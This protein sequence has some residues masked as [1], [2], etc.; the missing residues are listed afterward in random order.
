VNETISGSRASEPEE[1][2]KDYSI[3][4]SHRVNQ[5]PVTDP[6][7]D[8]HAQEAVLI[9]ACMSSD[10]SDCS[11]YTVRLVSSKPKHPKPTSLIIH[12]GKHKTRKTKMASMRLSVI[13]GTPP[14][15]CKGNV[16]IDPLHPPLS[17][18]NSIH[19]SG[20]TESVDK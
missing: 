10:A 7:N 2:D 12:D 8:R 11:F 9:S 13:S 16:I 5:T 1:V 19:P 15:C 20:V 18:Q 4:R 17:E 6:V 14:A 3:G